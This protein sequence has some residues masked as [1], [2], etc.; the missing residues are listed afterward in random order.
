MGERAWGGRFAYELGENQA[1]GI[2]HDHAALCEAVLYGPE[3]LDGSDAAD[4]VE[5][6]RVR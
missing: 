2:A 4:V 3:I 6:L 1:S 5:F